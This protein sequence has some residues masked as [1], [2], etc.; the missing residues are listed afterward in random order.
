MRRRGFREAQCWRGADH[1]TC[2]NAPTGVDEREGVAGFPYQKEGGRGNPGQVSI[3]FQ[4]E[5]KRFRRM[6][7]RARSRTVGLWL[8]ATWDRRSVGLTLIM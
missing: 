5:Q 8:T 4:R 1:S 3:I 7:R 2:I 6:A